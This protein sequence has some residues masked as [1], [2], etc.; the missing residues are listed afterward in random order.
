MI[1]L[2]T[3]QTTPQPSILAT[4]QEARI[5]QSVATALRSLSMLGIALS[6]IGLFV[7]ARFSYFFLSSHLINLR[8]RVS[9]AFQRTFWGD[10]GYR[11]WVKRVTCD[12]AVGFSR[13]I[14]NAIMHYE[15][16]GYTT[17]HVIDH[18]KEFEVHP[19]PS[20]TFIYTPTPPKP[21]SV[22]SGSD[23]DFLDVAKTY[24]DQGKRVAFM[25]PF[26]GQSA[27]KSYWEGAIHPSQEVRIHQRCLNTFLGWTSDVS[28]LERLIVLRDRHLNN[29]EIWTATMIKYSPS[30][31][32]LRES[33]RKI[34]EFALQ[35]E[36][37]VLVLPPFCSSDVVMEV[38]REYCRS[39]IQVVFAIQDPEVAKIYEEEIHKS[40]EK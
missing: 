34:Y 22:V 19:S 32:N 13:P 17:I 28:C 36:S 3:I 1:D 14:R 37:Q 2:S 38:H 15:A 10:A 26:K 35:F 27:T 21:V 23:V 39:G 31:T 6:A 30:T 25:S 7:A 24:V 5:T 8:Q 20:R 16:D 9:L 29:C 4:I 18:E 12:E 33:I 40:M 11:A